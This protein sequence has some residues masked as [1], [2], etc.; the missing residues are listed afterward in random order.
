MQ[1][2]R[3]EWFIGT[4]RRRDATIIL[5]W[6]LSIAAVFLQAIY[7]RASPN[8]LDDAIVLVICIVAGAALMELGRAILGYF[9]AIPLGMALVFFLTILPALDGT[10]GPPGDQLLITLW[11]SIIIKMIFPVQFLVFLFGSV[12]GSI[13]GEYYL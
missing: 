13:I 8:V 3:L 12:I 9:L 10:I 1:R 7:Q 4:R 11:L 5:L 2:N 6:T